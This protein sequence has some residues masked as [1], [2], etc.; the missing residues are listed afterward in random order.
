MTNNTDDDDVIE[1]YSEYKAKKMMKFLNSKQ[2]QSEKSTLRSEKLEQ[3]MRSNWL[4]LHNTYKSYE[5]VPPQNQ[6]KKIYDKNA[7]DLA[8]AQEH[9]YEAYDMKP[10]EES[11][12]SKGSSSSCSSSI[13]PKPNDSIKSNLKRAPSLDSLINSSASD[14][15]MD[16]QNSTHSDSDS[17]A[18]L[19]HLFPSKRD[20]RFSEMSDMINKRHSE[21]CKAEF[22]EVYHEKISKRCS[23]KNSEPK[24]MD[25]KINF[26]K[27]EIKEK[28]APF[29][30]LNAGLKPRDLGGSMTSLNSRK[31]SSFS[32][33]SSGPME[34]IIEEASEPKVSVKEILARFETMSEKSEVKH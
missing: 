7:L 34:T 28:K 19:S 13:S 18:D 25:P 31:F 6:Y 11:N 21:I 5:A 32:T 12:D 14:S 15:S 20:N 26:A 24:D 17:G 10:S 33:G 3:A 30:P 29:G 27:L 1:T 22:N 4:E 8:K 23:H 2:E 9:V 16:D